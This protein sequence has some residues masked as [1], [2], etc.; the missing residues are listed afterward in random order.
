LG[1]KVIHGLPSNAGDQQ[2]ASQSSAR[3]LVQFAHY[4]FSECLAF[5]GD[6]RREPGAGD[7]MLSHANEVTRLII[8]AAKG[9]P[10]D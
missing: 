7:H 6:G 8:D 10:I 1:L 5:A 4:A 2:F 3:A 9:V